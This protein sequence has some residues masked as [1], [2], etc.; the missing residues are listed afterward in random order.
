M[1]GKSNKQPYRGKRKRDFWNAMDP[2]DLL[3]DLHLRQYRQGPGSDEATGLA[4]ALSGLETG[5]ELKI[6][7]IGCGTGASTLALAGALD[8]NITAIDLFPAFLDELQRRADAAGV[9]DSITCNAASMDDLKF[10]EGS[11]DVIWSEGAIYNIGFETGIRQWRRFLKPGGILAVSELTWLTETRPSELAEHWNR[12]YPEVATASEKMRQ[13]EAAGYVPVGY[14]PLP[15]VCW[16]DHY[17]RPLQASFAG[18][19]ERHSGHTLA[20][21]IIDAEEF[22]IALYERHADYISYGFYIERRFDD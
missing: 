21:E 16:L 4:L 18:F 13:L 20:Q 10:D 17:Y 19:L 9:A 3:I 1:V 15:K 14:F 12:E 7:D 5:R 11:L 6:A 22:E 8:A 2:T